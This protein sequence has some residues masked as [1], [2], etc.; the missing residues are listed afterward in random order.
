MQFYRFS[1]WQAQGFA[2][3]A[4]NLADLDNAGV[5]GGRLYPCR[6]LSL[7]SGISGFGLIVSFFD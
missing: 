7:S 4:A 1:K 5:G 2:P 6:G 3:D